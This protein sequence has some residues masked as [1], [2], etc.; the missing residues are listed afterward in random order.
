MKQVCRCVLYARLSVTKEES[1]SI[2]RQLQSCRSYAQA[3]G[4]EVVGEFVD[5]GVSATANRPEERK[6]WAALLATGG[7]DAV[8]IWKVDRLARRVLD[9][10]HADEALQRRGAGL[11]AVEDPI[12][13]T[14]PQG[15]AFAVMLAV[16]GE[17]EAE[18]MRA[19]VRAA[20]SALLKVGRWP[21]GG[22][23]FGYLSVANPDGPGRV[24]AKDAE[25]IHWLAEVAAMALCGEAVN[26]IARWLT[27]EG[28]PVPGERKVSQ[29]DPIWNRQTVYGL[30][31]NPILAGMRPHNPG[32][33]RQGARVDPFSVVR[34]DV[35]VPVID[36]SLAVITL[37]EFTQL[38][39]LLDSRDL[40]QARKHGE[41]VTT[42]PFLSCVARCDDCDVFLCRG[43]N[44]G[45]PVLSCPQCR[46]TIGRTALDPY[47]AERL[48]TERG[49][50]PLGD[51]TVRDCWNVVKYN[52]SAKRD[53]LLTQLDFLYIR[54]GVVG[55]YFDEERIIL[56]WRRSADPAHSGI[57]DGNCHTWLE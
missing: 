19:R 5:D 32:R 2:A 55:R 35:G 30:L 54:R 47:L 20:R 18:A 42:S 44:Q 8:V 23:P 12:D 7:F 27:T 25:R 33:G 57:G 39:Q 40:P 48:L 17:M 10:L 43:T 24:L 16:F 34:D 41:R 37:D 3:R 36:E 13:M 9:F 22:I 11:V 4:W 45:R 21:G 28:A 56:A 1:V 50:E 14:S 46:Q 38:Q 52:E 31:R 49:G 15:R 53:I 26:A 51:S 6:G 29:S